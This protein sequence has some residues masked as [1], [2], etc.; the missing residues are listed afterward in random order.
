MPRKNIEMLLQIHQACGKP[1]YSVLEHITAEQL[2]WRPAPESRGIGEIMRHV[3]RVDIWF[4]NR[5]GYEPR[6]SDTKK[7]SV[8]DLISML[9]SSHSQIGEILDA[10]KDDKDLLRKSSAPDAR[11]D[12]DLG[13]VIRHISQHYL[14]HLAQMIYLRRAQDRQWES[15][16]KEWEYATHVIAD[17]LLMKG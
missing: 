1:L 10:C 4:L 9:E 8:E 11:E 6:A 17:F 15:P 13:G 5:L 7:P 3:V 16:I 14:Y 2:A 12:E